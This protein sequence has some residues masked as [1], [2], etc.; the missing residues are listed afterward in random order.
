MYKVK[1]LFMFLLNNVL[2]KSLTP[3]ILLKTSELQF[4]HRKAKSTLLRWVFCCN[5][6]II[7]CVK[8][9]RII[10]VLDMKKDLLNI[11]L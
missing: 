4:C 10:L 1:S 5:R 3:C 7:R 9:I 2:N 11:Y 8:T 6:L